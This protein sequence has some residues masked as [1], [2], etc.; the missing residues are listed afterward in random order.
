MAIDPTAIVVAAIG[1]LTGLAALINSVNTRRNAQEIRNQVRG[2]V[3]AEAY[4][5]AKTFYDHAIKTSREFQKELV[6]KLDAAQRDLT[7]AENT[8]NEM[9]ANLATERMQRQ[10]LEIQVSNLRLEVKY[11]KQRLHDAGFP[12]DTQDFDT[13]GDSAET[14]ES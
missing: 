4:E 5:V 7:T 1:S 12:V 3:D 8:L 2:K 11:L 6:E 13:A 9:T 14:P 10:Y